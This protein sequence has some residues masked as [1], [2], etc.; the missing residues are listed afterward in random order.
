MPRAIGSRCTHAGGP[1]AEGDILDRTPGAECVQCPWHGSVFRL[2]DGSVVHGPAN[3]PEPGYEVR[4]E[5]GKIHA[6]AWRLHHDPNEKQPSAEEMRQFREA[7]EEQQRRQ[8]RELLGTDR[9]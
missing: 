6:V 5:G 3:V 1:L 7:L 4:V 9:R 2:T 8:L